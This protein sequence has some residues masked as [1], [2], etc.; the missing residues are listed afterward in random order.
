MERSLNL[1]KQLQCLKY[2]AV[3]RSDFRIEHKILKDRN[4]FQGNPLPWLN[5]ID[6]EEAMVAAMADVN[7]DNN[8]SV[9][10][11]N[12]L[13]FSTDGNDALLS[14]IRKTNDRRFSK[15][16]AHHSKFVWFVNLTP[17]N[18]TQ[19]V[20]QG[21]PEGSHWVVI[22]A[23]LPSRIEYLHVHSPDIT[24]RVR[25]FDPMGGSLP[26]TVRTEFERLIHQQLVANAM[27][28]NI[29][30]ASS[31]LADNIQIHY[32][33]QNLGFQI[34]I[35]DGVQC[36]VFCIW[37]FH[38]YLVNNMDLSD[39]MNWTR[40][41]P[42]TT[43]ANREAFRMWYFRWNASKETPLS[44]S[45]SRK[46]KLTSD[47]SSSNSKNTKTQGGTSADTSAGTSA[48]PVDLDSDSD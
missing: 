3:D 25:Y 34:Q 17:V 35:H 46:R 47:G 43:P 36:G 1:V 38:Q 45:T 5:D 20:M 8:G 19:G 48:D 2:R 41:L 22:L 12:Q 30:F 28:L 29:E 39:M 27:R 37:F 42:Q 16:K 14:G 6:V 40:P 44:S 32:N 18:R 31:T 7:H 15:M 13:R 4:F 11:G 24:I 26:V 23:E 9:H 33:Y 10:F 21:R